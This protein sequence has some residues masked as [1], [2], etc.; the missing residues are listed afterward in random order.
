MIQ[1]LLIPS[2]FNHINITA[3]SN[4]PL[5]N[6]GD[7]FGFVYRNDCGNDENIDI[8][9]YDFEFTFS[10]GGCTYLSGG[11]VTG[12]LVKGTLLDN[13]KLWFNISTLVLDRGVYKYNI[14]IVGSNS[15]IKGDLIVR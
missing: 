7:A 1:E 9:L 4:E 12:E 6:A 15:V 13:N 3:K 10:L 14:K 8:S 5:N 11:T 2:E